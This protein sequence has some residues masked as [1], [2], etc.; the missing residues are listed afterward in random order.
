MDSAVEKI[1]RV[2]GT[3]KE[4]VPGGQVCV[5]LDVE[6]AR[7]GAPLPHDPSHLLFS[8]AGGENLGGVSGENGA[9]RCIWAEKS[10]K[11]KVRLIGLAPGDRVRCELSPFEP[12]RARIIDKL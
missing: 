4:L 8:G 7:T 6:L 9:G 1:I 3:V 12:G 5:E 11:L 10:A 2:E